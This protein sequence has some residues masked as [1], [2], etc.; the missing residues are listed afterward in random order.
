MCANLSIPQN[1]CYIN[2]WRDPPGIQT[3]PR[4]LN[5]RAVSWWRYDRIQ[6]DDWDPSRETMQWK[7]SAVNWRC[8]FLTVWKQDLPS[9]F[10]ESSPFPGEPTTHPSIRRSTN[11]DRDREYSLRADLPL[12]IRWAQ[13]MV[14]SI[15]D[16]SW[17]HFN[18]TSYFHVNENK[19]DKKTTF[20]NRD[21]VGKDNPSVNNKEEKL[22]VNKM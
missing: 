11:L 1:N 4:P 12:T 22:Q 13:R 10:H 20:R 9:Q 21:R 14:L 19:W 18:G 5:R 16:R 7:K 17:N 3:S 8:T 6:S 2:S 15:V